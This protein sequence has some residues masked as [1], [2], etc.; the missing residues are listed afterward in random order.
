M[1]A[2]GWGQLSKKTAGSSI[3]PVS[4]T[5]ASPA[6]TLYVSPSFTGTAA[7][8]YHYST[9]SAAIAA[10]SSGDVI[11]AYIPFTM[12]YAPKS[13]VQVIF[14]DAGGLTLPH[15]TNDTSWARIASG[16]LVFDQNIGGPSPTDYPTANGI[17]FRRLG[18]W[19]SAFS[20]GLDVKVGEPYPYFYL[21]NSGGYSNPEIT[22]D[23]F[24]VGPRRSDGAIGFGM[25][26]QVGTDTNS[27]SAVLSLFTGNSNKPDDVGLLISP[28]EL[29]GTR[30]GAGILVELR[31]FDVPTIN[32][33]G[34]KVKNYSPPGSYNYTFY[35]LLVGDSTTWRWGFRY[36]G[37][38]NLGLPTLSLQYL[39]NDATNGEQ[40]MLFDSS[41]NVTV[42]HKMTANEFEG[43]G[44]KITNV[45]NRVN[46]IDSTNLV[47]NGTFIN[48]DEWY[49][50][51]PDS[52]TISGGTLNYLAH[53]ADPNV[54]AELAVQSNVVFSIG[55]QYRVRF[56]TSNI[57]GDTAR[58]M[59]G[60]IGSIFEDT[61]NLTE[62]VY[63]A[64]FTASAD[65]V[66][67]LVY[68]SGDNPFSID[69]LAIYK[70][71]AKT[72]DILTWD[73]NYWKNTKHVDSLD[74]RAIT[75]NG[76]PVGTGGSGTLGG[77]TD[78]DTTG[79]VS[80]S[81]IKWNGAGWSIG[82]DITGGGGFSFSVDGSAAAGDSL[83]MHNAGLLSWSLSGNAIS[84]AVDTTTAFAY[85][86]NQLSGKQ[87]AGTYLV[88][89]DSTIQRSY[90]NSLYLKNADSTT[91][92]T[93]SNSLYLKN[94]DSTTLK[95]SVLSQV[96]KNAD[97]TSIRN[98]SGALYLKNA[99]STTLKNSVLSQV[100][101][102]ADSTSIRNYS[103][104]LYLKNADSTTLKNSVLSQVLKNADS[105][106][107]RNYS[108]ALY[109]KNADST[110]MKNSLLKN[111]DS[112]TQRTYS[113]S[114]YLKNADS[115]TMKNSLLKN[116][117]ST[118][119][120][121]YSNALYSDFVGWHKSGDAVVTDTLRFI[122][123]TN[124]TLT[125]SNSTL[126]IAGGAGTGTDTTIVAGSGVQ[127]SLSG[128]IKTLN[129]SPKAG[130]GLKITGDSL[131]V[132]GNVIGTNEA[133][134]GQILYQ[135]TTSP[136]TISGYDLSTFLTKSTILV[137]NGTGTDSVLLATTYRI[138]MG[139]STG[140]VL[141]TIV[142]VGM[143]VS[144]R[145]MQLG[146]YYGTDQSAAGALV[147]TTTVTSYNSLTKQ[148][149]ASINS[150]TIPAGN[151]VWLVPVSITTAFKT[152]MVYGLGHRL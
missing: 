9:I 101:K 60:K 133:T 94:A 108:G 7:D 45:V 68:M 95:N 48:G 50:N 115:T 113:N 143:G 116:A 23:I 87:A 19:K 52:M 85:I 44:T 73:G 46:I 34:L 152:I 63:Q 67:L 122:Q 144:N 78:V 74:F 107:I 146:I 12:A 86:K 97:S 33:A 59:I 17:V 103:G 149:G 40:V 138:P 30:Q 8:A 96:L 128:T 141:D 93:Y 26:S 2:A 75:V 100:L 39:G 123:G 36:S 22:G 71:K 130:T 58:V 6:K 114:L 119:I 64:D 98:Y 88:P 15:L 135:R 14:E 137:Q 99:D 32:R 125:Q 25:G 90:S 109:L 69:S 56:V 82:S 79:K 62:G 110:T 142:Y 4:R 66:N 102:N 55:T 91:Q 131:D 151:F 127:Q 112:T 57:M 132:D 47:R 89:N 76:L 111:A 106:S 53:T 80:G 41:L 31:R 3:D 27:A 21:W 24:A 148:Y 51:N 84:G 35:P 145:N 18:S 70:L 38:D 121:N 118:S 72:G 28:G 92:R 29:N 136:D 104:A 54:H 134:A 5:W 10:A 11:H 129:I 42:S 83:R 124:I 1:T 140:I 16:S 61:G 117:D 150:A 120:R 49:I 139:Y 105:T 37:F 81:V 126:T 43:D 20:M 13:G 77:L 147:D 65:T